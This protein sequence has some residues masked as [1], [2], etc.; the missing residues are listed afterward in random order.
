[1]SRLG[2]SDPPR[3]PRL[4]LSRAQKTFTRYWD[5]SIPSASVHPTQISK[6]N[7]FLQLVLVG[8]TTVAPLLPF[9]LSTPL[10]ALQYASEPSVQ[11]AAVHLFLDAFPHPC[12]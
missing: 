12:T 8:V 6:Y 4:T 1:M 2:S 7:T 9:D 11:E 3:L 5:F 10:W